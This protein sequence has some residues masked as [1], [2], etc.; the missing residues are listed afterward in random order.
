MRSYSLN[1]GQ[2]VTER[3][4]FAYRHLLV[5]MTVNEGTSFYDA[6]N[7]AAMALKQPPPRNLRNN[8][9]KASRRHHLGP[10]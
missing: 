7:D 5:L 10:G 3:G 8:E 6:R 4:V 2:P 1:R 9:S